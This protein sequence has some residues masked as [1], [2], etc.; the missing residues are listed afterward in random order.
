M[1]PVGSWAHGIG[2]EGLPVALPADDPGVV[3]ARGAAGWRLNDALHPAVRALFDLYLPL[4][5][6][7]SGQ[8]WVVAHLGQSLDGH[9]ATENGDSCYVTGPENLTHLHRMRALCDAIIVGAGTVAADDPRLTTRRVAGENPV[10][11][12]LDPGLRLPASHRIFDDGLAP[13]LV[14]QAREPGMK[15]T[16]RLGKATVL[17]VPARGRRLELASVREVLSASGLRR[18]FV[19]GGGATVSGFLQAGLLDR[20]QLAVA[21]LL[22]GSGRPGIRLPAIDSLAECLRPAVRLFRMGQDMLFDFDLN[23]PRGDSLAPVAM[24]EL[25]RIL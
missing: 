13:T 10:R 7:V 15:R 6:P 9:I 12:V 24:D 11:V 14:I 25:A 22:I 21:P 2:A 20:L 17:S 3:L 16:S 4:L 5:D 18:L 1:D 19:E 23:P 8:A